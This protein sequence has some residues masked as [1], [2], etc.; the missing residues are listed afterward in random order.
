MIISVQKSILSGEIVAPASKSYTHRAILAASL[1]TH[2]CRLF[3]CLM[4]ADTQSTIEACRLFGAD[5]EERIENG[6][7]VL[8]VK[9]FSGSPTVPQKEIDV[10]N[11]GTTLRLMA[12]LAGLCDEE[13][14]LTG[15]ASIQKRPNT[16][17]LKTLQDMGTKAV[18]KNNGCAPLVIR[19]PIQP[20]SV[21]IDGGMSSQ[22]ISALLLSCPLLKGETNLSVVGDFKSKP[23]VDVTL[24]VAKK[25][26]ILIHEMVTSS[27]IETIPKV[28]TSSKI[29]TKKDS[30]VVFSYKISGNQTYN[31]KEYT[32]PGDF[33]SVSY[34]LAAGALISGADVTVCNL[35]P[36]AQGDSAIISILEKMGAVVSWDKEKGI[37][38]VSNP[39]HRTLRGIVCD[40]K[41]TPDLVPTLAVLGAFSDGEMKIVNAAHVRL[42]ETDRLKAMATE[43]KKAGV[44]IEE[45]EDGL[46]ISGEKSKGKMKGADFHGWDDHR[47]VMSLFV[48]GLLLGNTTIDTTDS[49]KISYPEFFEVMKKV[50]AEWEKIE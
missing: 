17:L 48:A 12:A 28:E 7:T 32:I 13:I 31:L 49:V 38:S 3:H 43:L 18:S 11:S 42:K 44:F 29:E 6:E 20:G 26:G 5:I 22:F 39:D 46:I 23:Y 25:A 10:G 35:F 16:P 24:E 30:D 2:E 15:D 34:I 47:I 4:S 45:T 36:S 1:G 33:S 41:E 19:G 50:G 9:G 40:V 8:F 21:S 37:V 27:K 14:T